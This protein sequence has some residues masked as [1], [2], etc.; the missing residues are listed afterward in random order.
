M[1]EFNAILAVTDWMLAFLA[2]DHRAS[3][4]VS[5]HAAAAW[6][7]AGSGRHIGEF[8]EQFFGV[9]GGR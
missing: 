5:A 4:V 6:P 9:L 2:F 3:V 1:R 7:Y 8:R